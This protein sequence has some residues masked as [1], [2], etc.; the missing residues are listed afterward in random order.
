MV[1]ITTLRPLDSIHAGPAVGFPAAPLA[2]SPPPGDSADSSPIY[3][4]PFL[5]SSVILYSA[6]A[7]DL[8]PFSRTTDKT[9]IL[10]ISAPR[11]LTFHGLTFHRPTFHELTFHKTYVS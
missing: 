9:T 11:G 10:S 6:L 7:L 5:F 4:L 3:V 2:H 1:V 8:I